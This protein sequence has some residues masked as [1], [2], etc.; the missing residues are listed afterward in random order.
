MNELILEIVRLFFIM[1]ENKNDNENDGKTI[2]FNPIWFPETIIE[3]KTR[4]QPKTKDPYKFKLSSSVSSISSTYIEFTIQTIKGPFKKFL[5]GETLLF[6]YRSDTEEIVYDPDSIVDGEK[7]IKEALA[8]LIFYYKLFF[9]TRWTSLDRMKERLIKTKDNSTPKSDLENSF[10]EFFINRET[11]DREV[12]LLNEEIKNQTKRIKRER[13]IKCTIKSLERKFDWSNYH[14]I[15]LLLNQKGTFVDLSLPEKV[16]NVRIEGPF[17]PNPISVLMVFD[18]LWDLYCFVLQ[19]KQDGENENLS[20]GRFEDWFVGMKKKKQTRYWSEMKSTPFDLFST[21]LLV[22]RNII[23]QSKELKELLFPTI[24]EDSN[25]MEIGTLFAKLDKLLKPDE[26]IKLFNDLSRLEMLYKRGLKKAKEKIRQQYI[27]MIMIEYDV[28]HTEK[29][30]ENKDDTSISK[31]IHRERLMDCLKD[32]KLFSEKN[33]QLIGQYFELWFSTENTTHETFIRD[34]RTGLMKIAK[35][36]I[37]DYVYL[38]KRMIERFLMRNNKRIEALSNNVIRF[39]QILHATTSGF[40]LEI[41][42]KQWRL[43]KRCSNYFINLVKDTIK[44]AIL[45]LQANDVSNILKVQKV[46]SSS[47]IGV[48]AHDGVNPF[49]NVRLTVPTTGWKIQI[50]KVYEV[51]NQI[52]VLSKVSPPRGDNIVVG[53]AISTVKDSASMHLHDYHRHKYPIKHFIIGTTLMSM[54][55]GKERDY[56]Y[57]KSQKEFDV[58]LSLKK[59]VK[60]IFI[61]VMHLIGHR[62]RIRRRRGKKRSNRFSRGLHKKLPLKI[63]PPRRGK[64][65]PPYY[66]RSVGRGREIGYS[67]RYPYRY[68][69]KPVYDRLTGTFLYWSLIDSLVSR[70]YHHCDCNR[71]NDDEKEC[72]NGGWMYLNDSI[73]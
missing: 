24:T 25:P 53:Q 23:F 33:L 58:L 2:S 61:D 18:Y 49:V 71:V 54:G 41:K 3:I 59:D 64:K 6:G 57:L 8:G 62:I 11:K 29:K 15:F 56:T 60:E 1:N 17:I 47:L 19:K 28:L 67:L 69:Y 32:R 12:V 31:F 10:F 52:W 13:R 48:R 27:S 65:V 45:E 22:L 37:N 16:L 55:K 26:K 9:P 43:S 14:I 72:E 66:T 40:L 21:C 7:G 34:Q 44:A 63:Y 70:Y 39:L 50:W 5:I 42:D 68:Y 4:F 30:E 20:L 36:S 35:V 51:E 73:N 46:S 38:D